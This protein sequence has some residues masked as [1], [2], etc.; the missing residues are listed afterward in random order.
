MKK[1]FAIL[2][3]HTLL[4]T[5]FFSCT[6]HAGDVVE[7]AVPSAT[8]AFSS[9]TAGAVYQ[10]GDSVLIQGIAI[11]TETIHGYEIDIKNGTDTSVVYFSEH[12]HD[13]NDTIVIN[14]K[15]KNTLPAATNLR[16]DVTLHLDHDGHT[17]RKAVGFS[18]QN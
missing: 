5:A 4:L 15:W 13:H 16:V 3:L 6:K 1:T 7:E 12:V 11:S 18:T 10:S 14:K 17:L 8:F 9:P 2:S